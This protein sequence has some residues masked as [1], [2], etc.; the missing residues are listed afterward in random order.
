MKKDYGS[1]DKYIWGFVKGK[2]KVN[3]FKN[4]QE[5]PV[6]T[7][8]SIVMS[9]DLKRRGFNFIGTTICYAFMQAIGMVNDHGVDCFRW[10][11][12]QNNF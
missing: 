8:E 4:L 6:I 1:F 2:S 11:E 12:V 9:K 10:K 7:K 5:I 3:T